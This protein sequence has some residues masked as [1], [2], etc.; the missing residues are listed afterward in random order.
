MYNILLKQ[1]KIK[2][3]IFLLGIFSSLLSTVI[4]LLIPILSKNII[5]AVSG[6]N[7]SLSSFSNVILLF[8]FQAAA[9]TVSVV[10]LSYIGE[11]IV[12][13]FRIIVWEKIIS[14]RIRYFENNKSG[15]ITSLLVND[16]GVIKNFISNKI[17]S[18]I[19]SVISLIGAVIILMCIDYKMTLLIF[20]VFPILLL[21]VL[22][23]GRKIKHRSQ[24]Y[25]QELSEFTGYA[26]QIISEIKLVKY[27]NSE[28][29]E[30]KRGTTQLN[31]LFRIGF[32]LTKI[33]SLGNSLILLVMT[34]MLI[35]LLVF[36]A[37]RISKQEISTGTLLAFL[38]YLLQ[39]ISPTIIILS[40]VNQLKSV[41]G[42]SK[43]VIDLLELDVED[44]SKGQEINIE[45]QPLKF[46]N[47]NFEYDYGINVLKDVSFEVQPKH[48]VAFVGPS[49]AG[50]TTIF[51]LIERFYDLKEGDILFGNHSILD[52]PIKN[53]RSQVGY[54]SQENSLLSGTIYDNLI[55]GLRFSVSEN[56][57]IQA[58][59]QSC[60]L[61]FVNLLPKG[62]H[63]N[64]GEKGTKLSG[65]EKQRIAIARAFLRSPKILLLDEATANLD[66][67]SEEVVQQALKNLMRERMTLIIAHRLS[68]VI[69]A[70]KIIFI[71]NGQITGEGKH[72]ELIKS[73]SLYKEYVESQFM[74]V[75][76][77]QSYS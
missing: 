20:A 13:G 58:L 27:S 63:T 2:K 77:S 3:T 23:M 44:L 64:I 46:K 10:S 51:G 54:V 71:E 22:P 14:L 37:V 18:L 73:H 41:Q 28:N 24:Q 5:D 53:L 30:K 7:L 32:N 74:N 9:S 1:L 47:V 60:A 57:C 62:I 40:F 16:T 75:K 45:N 55:Y 66:S 26:N 19:T 48:T 68:T 50:K 12:G 72:L 21:I 65:G 38:M 36:G 8:I 59:S 17:P 15:E 70:D 34:S 49:G 61:E 39:V 52:V 6:K 11:G 31:S 33:E 56:Q 67:S 43:R 42:A 69:D 29:Y 76:E 4:S 25:Q 35:C